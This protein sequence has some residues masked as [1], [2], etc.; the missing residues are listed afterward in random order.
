MILPKM[1]LREIKRAVLSDY[2]NEVLRKLNNLA[3]THK[4]KW[5]LNG[6]KNYTE[7]IFYPTKSANKWRVV[8]H[9]TKDNVHLMPYVCS[10]NSYGIMA[11]HLSTVVEPQAF[12]HFNTHFFKRLKERLN[13]SIEKPRELVKVFFKNNLYMIPAITERSDG[14]EQIFTILQGGVG[15]GKYHEQEEIIEFKTFVSNE[16]LTKRQQKLVVDTAMD[17]YSRINTALLNS[18][19]RGQSN[20]NP[21]I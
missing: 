8:V 18:L 7:T 6:K 4:R 10:Y 14:S 19:K 9:C 11:A 20:P 17:I 16:M 1:S 2:H 15:L 3:V 5:Q 12:M 21:G 13:I